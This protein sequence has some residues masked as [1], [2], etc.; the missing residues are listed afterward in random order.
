MTKCYIIF[1]LIISSGRSIF[2]SDNK[3]LIEPKLL[4]QTE[5]PPLRVYLGKNNFEFLCEI[6]INSNGDVERAK[7]LTKSDDPVWD[8]LTVISLLNWKYSPAIYNGQPV[9]IMIRR[10]VKIIFAEP[11]LFTLEEIQVTNKSTADSIYIALL[12]GADFGSLASLHS[13]S[14]SRI[15]NGYIGVIN[16][17][18]YSNDIRLELNKLDY[19]EFTKP[20][21]Y[22][23]GF[24]LFKRLRMNNK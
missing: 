4:K 14:R 1:F 7:L 18:Y 13:I 8:S 21:I 24:I 2:Q 23:S 16:I 12:D 6:Y 15:N 20:I 9:A 11:Q 5:L 3:T 10:T 22:G 19:N 17:K